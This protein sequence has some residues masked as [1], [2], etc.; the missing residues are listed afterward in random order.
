MIHQPFTAYFLGTA[1]TI[2]LEGEEMFELRNAIADIYAQN[3]GKPV[4][5]IQ[6]D[7]ERD[8]YM[9][10]TEAQAYGIVDRIAKLKEQ[11]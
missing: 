8:S 10:A 4:S 7:L 3:T 9:S 1:K 5:V 6:K 11:N 2:V